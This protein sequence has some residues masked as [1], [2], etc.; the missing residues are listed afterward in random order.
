MS[1]VWLVVG[2][3]CCSEVGVCLSEWASEGLWAVLV[4]LVVEDVDEILGGS[5]DVSELVD[6]ARHF[7]DLGDG[8]VDFVGESLNFELFVASQGFLLSR[9]IR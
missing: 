8:S 3:E 7:F 9:C 5:L 6:L 2:A 1:S 4:E